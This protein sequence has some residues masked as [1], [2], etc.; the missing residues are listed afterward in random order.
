[1]SMIQWNLFGNIWIENVG[2]IDLKMYFALENSNKFW[3]KKL[4][5]DVV[6]LGANTS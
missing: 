4:V 5:E 1:M 3:K 2:N 6:T